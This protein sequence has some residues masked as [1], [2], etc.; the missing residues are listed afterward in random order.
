MLK[1]KILLRTEQKSLFLCF[2]NRWEFFLVWLTCNLSQSPDGRKS[3]RFALRLLI[4][5]FSRM[6]NPGVATDRHTHH[7]RLVIFLIFFN[8][9]ADTELCS[10]VR[11]VCYLAES[12][13]PDTA[14]KA[15]PCARR[16]LQGGDGSAGRPVVN[17]FGQTPYVILGQHTPDE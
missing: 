9:V 11:S 3:R 1:K 6:K 14:R 12:L 17:S 15:E 7:W 16:C 8:F 10:H 13:D 4:N 2:L 5:R